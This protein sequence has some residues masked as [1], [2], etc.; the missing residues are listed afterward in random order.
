MRHL[1]QSSAQ[2]QKTRDQKH[3]Q[4]PILLELVCQ[5]PGRLIKVV[6]GVVVY[7]SADECEGLAAE[8]VPVLTAMSRA[9]R[10]LHEVDYMGHTDTVCSGERVRW[11]ALRSPSGQVVGMLAHVQPS[12]RSRE[13]VSA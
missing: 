6:N 4:L 8:K 5:I 1:Q 3:V 7:D 2:I 10:L 11:S 9:I 12:P 13:H